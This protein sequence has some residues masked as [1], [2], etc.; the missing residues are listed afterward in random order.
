M[1]TPE[2][3]GEKQ[4]KGKGKL[5]Q[6]GQSGNPNGRPKGSVSVVEALKRRMTEYY[7]DPTKPQDNES[8]RTHLEALV[9]AWFEN[10]LKIRDQRA[11]KDMVSYIDGLPKQTVTIDGDK[12]SLDALTQ[13]FKAVGASKKK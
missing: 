1:S 7:I 8:R 9:D 4:N 13:Y 10:A 5:F 6:K 11:I 2:K 3:T 12:E